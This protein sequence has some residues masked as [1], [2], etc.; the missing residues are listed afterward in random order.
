MLTKM[1]I[2]HM[3]F[4]STSSTE[5][6]HPLPTS[7]LPQRR[8]TRCVTTPVLT[9]RARHTGCDRR[10]GC[11]SCRRSRPWAWGCRRRRGWPPWCTGCS[12][13]W[14]GARAGSSAC[15]PRRWR[16]QSPLRNRQWW[17]KKNG[18]ILLWLN[19]LFFNVSQLQ[20][21]TASAFECEWASVSLPGNG[22]SMS[23]WSIS[24]SCAVFDPGA[25]HMSKICTTMENLYSI[26]SRR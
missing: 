19:F 26:C 3:M 20:T 15:C 24:M 23:E 25:A 4:L 1:S 9:C 5:P 18:D 13:A 2:C 8:R 17:Q 21:A 6:P 10:K 12:A 22:T 11:P 7:T 16:W 14:L